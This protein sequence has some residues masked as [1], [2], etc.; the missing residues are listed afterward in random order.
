[1]PATP[2]R[3]RRAVRIAVVA[4]GCFAA[5]CTGSPGAGTACPAIGWSN[6]LVVPAPATVGPVEV[7][8]DGACVRPDDLAAGAAP[9]PPF[10]GAAQVGPGW[11]LELTVASDV[12]RVRRT[13]ADGAVV[14][15][16][17][18]RPRWSRTGG[19]EECGGPLRAVLPG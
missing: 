9:T 19:T 10:L 3:G 8:V 14:S 6:T 1:M 18:V 5:G 13:G 11:E 2:T 15:D 17:S 12:V 16:R 4:A 7:C